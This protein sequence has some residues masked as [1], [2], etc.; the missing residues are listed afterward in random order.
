MN[1]KDEA[2]SI[3]HGPSACK[4]ITE[5]IERNEVDQKEVRK[6]IIKIV[7]TDEEQDWVKC[8]V[9][10]RLRAIVPCSFIQDSV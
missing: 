6:T 7:I 3:S 8:S 9:I 10:G 5:N 1:G 4:T 2:L